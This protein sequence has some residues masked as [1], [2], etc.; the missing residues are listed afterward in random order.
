MNIL[1]VQV[2]FPGRFSDAF[3]ISPELGFA[4]FLG[5]GIP[6]P[7][8]LVLY[9]VVFMFIKKMQIPWSVSS[10]YPATNQTNLREILCCYSN[11]VKFRFGE[12]EVECVF[13]NR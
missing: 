10:A 5:G 8:E 6:N 4:N 11:N 7:L 9:W 13:L 12:K 3:K 1:R 2:T